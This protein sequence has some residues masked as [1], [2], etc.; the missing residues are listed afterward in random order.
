MEVACITSDYRILERAT[1][2]IRTSSLRSIE[3]IPNT[4]ENAK[5]Q[6]NTTESWNAG[7]EVVVN[8]NESFAKL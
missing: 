8:Q 5:A 7:V 3:H 6:S 4:Q 1:D 2:Y